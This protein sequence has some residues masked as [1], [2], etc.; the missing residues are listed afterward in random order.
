[1]PSATPPEHDLGSFSRVART[2]TS[3]RMPRTAF[4]LSLLSVIGVVVSGG[5]ALVLF[6][7]VGV[8]SLYGLIAVLGIL[9]V[10]AVSF[11]VALSQI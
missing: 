7:V 9:I 11:V 10:V 3:P 6:G 5:V 2:N 1:M 8:S 4:V